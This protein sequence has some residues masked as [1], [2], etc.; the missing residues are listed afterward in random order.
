MAQK[1]FPGHGHL[2]YESDGE[3]ASLLQGAGF[4]SIGHRVKGSPESP[5]RRLALATA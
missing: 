2:L 1:H 3:V 4:A 5:E